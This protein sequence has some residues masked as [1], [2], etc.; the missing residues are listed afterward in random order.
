MVNFF[1]R[2]VPTAAHHMQPLFAALAGK[3]RQSHLVWTDEMSSAFTAT[4]QA[5]AEATMLAHPRPDAPTAL[6]VD[7]SDRA[8]GGVL[9]QCIDGLW[10]PLAFFSQQLQPPETKYSAFNCELL[11]A[12]LAVRHFHFFLE[13]RI[14]TIYMD[15]KPLTLAMH[16]VSEP[17]SARQQHH[18]SAISEFTTDIQHVA[19][20][21][22]PVADALLRAT[23]NL[24]VST[25]FDY[26]AMSAAQQEDPDLA[27]CRTTT[28]SL[29][30]AQL[31][32]GEDGLT[33]ACDISTG[34]PRP[35]VPPSWR[36]RVFD[37]LHNLSHPGVRASRKLVSSKFV[38]YGMNKHISE[39]AKACIACQMSKVAR[40]IRAPLRQFELPHRRFDN[41]NVDLVG[42]LPPSQGFSYLFTIVDRFTRWPEAIPLTDISSA[43]CARA[44]L[45]HWV[46]RFGLPSN[47]SSDRG[48][49]FMSQ[50][51]TALA[52]LLGAKLH[53]TTAYH[54]Q[55][56]GLIE[57]FHQHLKAALRAR[58]T[59]AN[60]I[61]VL[62]WVLLGIRTAPKAD[63]RTSS[64][65]LI[66]GAPLTVPG[67]FIAT[68]S[69]TIS[70]SQHLQ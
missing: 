7:A 19:G 44:F 52:E 36:R 45:F 69:S 48:V 50:L 28:S 23:I 29:Q 17:W 2:F 20:K 34:T 68:P 38:W 32:F 51:W 65:E 42:P 43:T 22:N 57:R 40:H 55:A 25:G 49:Q 60:W 8:I 39:W 66:Y 53:H 64:A 67:D 1:H 3:S 9:E 26:S 37:V 11:A 63:L 27:S 5:L 16:K 30:L 14:F 15:H 10:Q 18:L 31:P 58:L 12:H 33:L 62:P 70:H 4:K 61:D 47:I 24:I 35:I 41:I 13:G 6:T 21:D 59:D 54:P 56:N 46:S